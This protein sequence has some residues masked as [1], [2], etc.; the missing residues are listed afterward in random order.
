MIDRTFKEAV[1]L[2]RLLIFD[3]FITESFRPAFLYKSYR[4]LALFPSAE[5]LVKHLIA[6]KNANRC[7]YGDTYQ[8]NDYLFTWDD[9]HIYD[10]NYISAKF[11]EATRKF[12]RPEITL[13][14]LRHTC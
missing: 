10:P 3:F 7:F 8:D 14:K 5:T 13:H 11:T 9:G 6:E 4:T 12:G 2:G 1:I